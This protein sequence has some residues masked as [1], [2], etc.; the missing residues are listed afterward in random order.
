[1]KYAYRRFTDYEEFATFTN[2]SS[3]GFGWHL[4]SWQDIGGNDG[5]DIRAIYTSP[6]SSV[7]DLP[8]K[9]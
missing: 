8:E 6:S 9:V 2:R 3:L 7:Y 5:I 1:M 4:D